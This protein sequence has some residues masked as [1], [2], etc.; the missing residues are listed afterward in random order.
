MDEIEEIKRR[1]MEEMMKRKLGPGHPIDLTD[2]NFERVVLETPR[3]VV[4]FW[5]EWCMPCKVMG[6]IVEELAQMFK[7]AVLFGK[8]NI[9]EN[10]MTAR[11]YGIT[12]IPTL[13][14]FRDG[15]L[16]DTTVGVLPRETLIA[17]VKALS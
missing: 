15:K 11:K 5:A 14:F 16:V 10:P 1:K 12:A 9:D 3:L 6:P 8:I 2:E 17:K 7:G 13:L 4:D